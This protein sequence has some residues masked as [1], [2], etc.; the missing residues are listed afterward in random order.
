MKSID[1]LMHR[2]RKR[3]AAGGA[4]GVVSTVWGAGYIMREPA[5]ATEVLAPLARAMH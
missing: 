5:L 3:L 2:L 4:D 1:V